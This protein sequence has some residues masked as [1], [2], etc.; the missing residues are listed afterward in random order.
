MVA[1][2]RGAVGRHP[3]DEELSRL[4][5]DLTRVSARFAELW[6]AGAVATHMVARKVVDHPEIG[7]IALDCDVLTV[8]GVDLRIVAYTAEPG[9]EA[10]E[11][12]ALLRVI[13]VQS[14]RTPG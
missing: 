3:R 9:S 2:L 5:A 8:R 10:A 4:V 1:D 11:K 14:I 13:G 6:A 7:P 12:L